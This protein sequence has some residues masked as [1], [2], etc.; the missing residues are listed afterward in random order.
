MDGPL[1]IN[2]TGDIF[3]MVDDEQTPKRLTGSKALK[4]HIQAARQVSKILRTSLGPCGFDKMFVNPCGKISSTSNGVT[5]LKNMGNDNYIEKLFVELAQSQDEEF[6]DGTTG[7]VVFAGALLE[8]ASILLNRGLR[9]L[10]IVDLYDLALRKSIERLE[11]IAEKFTDYDHEILVKA[12]STA[13]GSKIVEESK[14]KIAEIVVKA[15]LAAMDKERQDVDFESIKIV[16][17]A[18]GHVEDSQMFNGVLIEKSFAHPQMPKELK[19][20]QVAILSCPLEPSKPKIKEHL[21][22]KGDADEKTLQDSERESLK[23]M[24][25]ELKDVNAGL[26]ICSWGLDGEA[27]ELL[28]QNDLPAACLVEKSNINQI[29]T[30]TKSCVV[31]RFAELSEQK[32]GKAATVREINFGHSK[33]PMLLIEGTESKTVSLMLRGG[34]ELAIDETEQAVRDAMCVVRNLI[35]DSRIVY[36]GGSAELA[37]SIAV[38]K[39]ADKIDGLLH[40]AY[41]AYGKAL[42]SIPIALSQNSKLKTNSTLATLKERQCKEENPHL[43]VD[44]LQTGEPD[45]KKQGIVEALTSKREQFSLATQLVRTILKVDDVR[46]K[47]N[48]LA[49]IH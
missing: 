17:K 49:A 34:S 1:C 8:Q 15:A 41:R 10:Q 26:V 42:E 30:V 3:M 38:N 44:C 7:V 35:R 36:G 11:Q 39:V 37:C 16:K 13:F 12:A 2:Q 28:Q 21:D 24:I 46:I 43:G 40:F 29:A 33:K 31:P 6:G 9:P 22:A 14:Q 48:M 25:S 23:K 19:D 4:T 47:G 18:G 5:I 45:M 20:V 32:L 27:K